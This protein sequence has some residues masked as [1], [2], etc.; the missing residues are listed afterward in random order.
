MTGVNAFVKLDDG[1]TEVV[2]DCNAKVTAID[3]FDT[4]LYLELEKDDSVTYIDMDR[5]VS[6]TLKKVSTQ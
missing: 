4:T 2:M 6:F 1:K 5:V 3:D